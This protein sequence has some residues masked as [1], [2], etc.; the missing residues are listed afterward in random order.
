M[1]PS[2][3]SE[4][5]ASASSATS[6]CGEFIMRSGRWSV[7]NAV[8]TGPRI[9]ADRQ[10]IRQVQDWRCNS[11]SISDPRGSPSIR[12]KILSGLIV[13]ATITTVAHPAVAQVSIAISIA[14]ISEN[15]IAKAI[16]PWSA[17]VPTA[18]A[19]IVAVNKLAALV[20]G[21]RTAKYPAPTM[22]T[23]AALCGGCCWNHY[24]QQH[25]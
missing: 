25:C 13:I 14:S 8:L 16:P 1:S 17:A 21:M 10:R 24:C 20:L 11:L 19:R 7:K 4:T 3:A 6:A 5:C 9:Y 2:Q 22:A 12:G 18:I 23:S 15:E